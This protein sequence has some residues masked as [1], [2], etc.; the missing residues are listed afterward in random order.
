MFT[1]TEKV[2]HGVARTVNR[3]AVYKRWS[4]GFL[5][6]FG[7]A[8]VRFCSRNLVELN[9]VEILQKLAPERGVLLASNHRNYADMYLLSS[10]VLPRCR[11]IQRMYFPVRAEFFYDRIAGLFVNAFFS[12]MSMYPPVHRQASRRGLNRDSV[13]FLV[14]ELRRPGTL[15]GMHPEGRRGKTDDPYVLLPAQPGLGEIVHRAQPVVIP[16]FINGVPGNLLTGLWG[17]FRTGRT[18]VTITIT[19]GEPM[20]FDAERESPPGARTSLRIA[21]AIRAEIERLGAQDRVL[22]YSLRKARV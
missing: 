19:F 15:V 2:V 6:T 11:W 17:N 8:W 9:N 22:R 12:G 4:H 20:A 21:Q 1:R 18:P 7:T 16:V 5:R 3:R 13:S 14:N 10:I